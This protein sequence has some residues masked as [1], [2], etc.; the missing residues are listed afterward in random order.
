MA[1]ARHPLRDARSVKLLTAELNVKRSELND[2]SLK[3]S[4]TFHF[5]YLGIG[6]NTRGHVGWR[7]T[8]RSKPLLE[9]LDFDLRYD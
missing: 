9:I 5:K 8:Y 7:A 6:K 2:I 3:G 1:A 4:L